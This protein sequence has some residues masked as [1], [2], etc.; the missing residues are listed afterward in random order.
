MVWKQLVFINKKRKRNKT[1]LH[2]INKINSRE[3]GDVVVE[4]KLLKTS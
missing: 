4:G 1:L 2:N 3:I